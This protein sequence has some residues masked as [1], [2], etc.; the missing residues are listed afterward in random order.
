MQIRPK[1]FLI[2]LE[3]LFDGASGMFGI[4]ASII[5]PSKH[6][7]CIKIQKELDCE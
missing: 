4:I 5:V 6:L 7:V 1:E 2:F 3:S